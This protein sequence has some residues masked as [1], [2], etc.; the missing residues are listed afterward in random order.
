MIIAVL[1]L[2][3][4]C[5]RQ[6]KNKKQNWEKKQLLFEKKVVLLLCKKE[7]EAGDLKVLFKFLPCL[8]LLF[9]TPRKGA[10]F[11]FLKGK[12]LETSPEFQCAFCKKKSKQLTKQK[13]L[14]SKCFL[15]LQAYSFEE[16]FSQFRFH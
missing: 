1:Q 13:D 14:K 4:N 7:T 6:K 10:K 16:V 2:T 11:C 15:F 12:T 8:N 5:C 3:T 9:F